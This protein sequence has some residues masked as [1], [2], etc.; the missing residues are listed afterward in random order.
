MR[1]RNR[2][3]RRSGATAEGATCSHSQPTLSCRFIVRKKFEEIAGNFAGMRKPLHLRPMRCGR[4]GGSEEF[5]QEP[6][7][8]SDSPA[9]HEARCHAAGQKLNCFSSE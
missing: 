1:P 5:V 8:G 3:S 6:P 4:L 9:R 7:P 2:G